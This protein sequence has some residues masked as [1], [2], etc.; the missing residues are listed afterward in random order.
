M[1]FRIIADLLPTPVKCRA[2]SADLLRQRGK[3]AGTRLITYLVGSDPEWTFM[4]II[5]G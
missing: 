5:I 1:F 2:S 3:R 4:G